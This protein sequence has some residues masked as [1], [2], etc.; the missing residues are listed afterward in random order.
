MADLGMN[1]YV[2]SSPDNMTAYLFLGTPGENQMYDVE[3]IMDYL[4]EQ[5]IAAGIIRSNVEAMVSKRIYLREVKVAE[6]TAATEGHEGYYEFR[7]SDSSAKR[8][9]II[10]SD[11]SVDYQS[12]SEIENVSANSILAVYH[13][14][15]KGTPGID[16]KGN[17]MNPKP[18]RDLPILRG[19]GI[20]RSEDGNTYTAQIDGRVEYGNYKLSVKNVYEVRDDVDLIVGKIDFRGD[21]II[22]GN[23]SAGVEIR[24]TK[25]IVINGH[26]EAATLIAA[27]DITLKKG[28]QG[29]QKSVIMAGGSVYAEFLEFVKLKVDKDIHAN[30]IMNCDIEAGGRI[31]VSGKKGVIMG[32]TIYA[33][34]GIE[35]ANIG[36]DVALK[37]VVKVGLSEDLLMKERMSVTRTNMLKKGIEKAEK[38]IDELQNSKKDILSQGSIEAK[39][40]QLKKKIA[41][42]RAK[43]EKSEEEHEQINSRIHSSENASIRVELELFSGTQI[44]IGSNCKNII[45][46]I[47]G[48]EFFGRAG[49]TEIFRRDL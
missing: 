34:E 23:V 46:T 3:S 36:N 32:G 8:N 27:G 29:G 39:I 19:K 41:R 14:A 10:R 44:W 24:A 26:V 48:V 45:Q 16:I 22:Y 1:T 21:V 6:G 40:S 18:V 35:S 4:L 13:P 37:T 25:N 38:Q 42:D 31:T 9:P 12:M 2:K 30:V 20:I 33:V 5:G 43:I 28:M 47:K 7:F 17:V 11:G 49:E 15:I